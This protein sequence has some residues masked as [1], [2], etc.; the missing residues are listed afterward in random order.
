M[1]ALAIPVVG[2][3]VWND[4]PIK[5]NHLQ[6]AKIWQRDFSGVKSVSRYLPD[7]HDC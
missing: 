3:S 4:Y 5:N 1:M 2:K 7:R 6:L